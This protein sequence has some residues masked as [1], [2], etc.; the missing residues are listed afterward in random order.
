MKFVYPLGLLG[1]IAIPILIL[2]YI[3]LNKY[4]EQTVTSTYLWTLS[5]R[6]LK[7]RNP[8]SM[9]AGI[10]SLILQILA[11]TM[12]SFAIAQPMIVIPN[13]A[14]AYCFVLD[15]SGSMNMTLNGKSRF[16]VAKGEIAD[17]IKHSMNGS[18]Y[19]LVTRYNR[20]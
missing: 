16:D 5:E 19:T 9:I 14:N 7:R 15:G 6:F 2:I 10:I 11:I 17:I 3:I 18:T 20:N 1:L 8:I 12:I 13:S 4:T